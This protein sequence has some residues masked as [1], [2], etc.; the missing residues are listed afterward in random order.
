MPYCEFDIG[1]D[2]VLY[3]RLGSGG[4]YG[5]PVDRDPEAVAESLLNGRVS[6]A[7]A[8]DIYGAV[9]EEGTSNLDE[10]ATRQLRA[11]LRDGRFEK[12]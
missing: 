5:D 8:E 12:L 7:A 1:K 2:D 11:S 9:M 4:G 10:A 3:L 6:R